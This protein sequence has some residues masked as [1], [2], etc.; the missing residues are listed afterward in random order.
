MMPVNPADRPL[1]ALRDEVVDRLIMNYG[2]GTLSLEAF[3][4]RLDDAFDA[5]DHDTLTGL[6]ADLELEVDAGYVASKRAELRADGFDDE[7]GDIETLVCIFGGSDRT[8]RWTVPAEVRC[9]TIFGG[10]DIDFTEAVFTA[11]VTRVRLF[12]LFG[13]VDILVPEGVNTT[14]KAFAVF[15]GVDNRTPTCPDRDAP[16]LIVEGLVLF[17]GADV[18]FKRSLKERMLELADRLKARLQ[19]NER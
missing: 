2:H 14:V 12:C 1:D 16:R 7:A 18:K 19:G 8:G 3:Q 11:P 10:A 6:V 15:G 5:T 9:I 17:G 4:R 13:G